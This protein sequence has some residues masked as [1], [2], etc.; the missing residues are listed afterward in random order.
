MPVLASTP[1]NSTSTVLADIKQHTLCWGTTSTALSQ[2]FKTSRTPDTTPHGNTP[3]APQTTRL[4]APTAQ[5]APLPHLCVPRCCWCGRWRH[6]DKRPPRGQCSAQIAAASGSQA[7]KGA[8][9]EVKVQQRVEVQPEAAV[10]AA[11][12]AQQVEVRFQQQ[13]EVEVRLQQ[14][15]K[16]KPAAAV[17]A[18]AVAQQVEVEVRWRSRVHGRAARGTGIGAHGTRLGNL[19]RG[20]VSGKLQWQGRVLEA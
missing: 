19:E 7:C 20:G 2:Q 1:T 16:A 17:A 6:W 12:V 18:A 5:H 4:P 15:V 14:Q 13:V 3:A 10:A 9:V 11:A 8:A